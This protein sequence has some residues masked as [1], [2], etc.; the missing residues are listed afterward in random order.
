[1]VVTLRS[2][3]REARAA[4]ASAHAPLVD[5]S[6]S[7]EGDGDRG[8]PTWVPSGPEGFDVSS[9]SPPGSPM[10]ADETNAPGENVGFNLGAGSFTPKKSRRPRSNA[11]SGHTRGSRRAASP[12]PTTPPPTAGSESPELPSLSLFD[13][14]S[15]PVRPG[16]RT[17]DAAS[18]G[19]PRRSASTPTPVTHASASGTPESIPASTA[20]PFKK[21]PGVVGDASPFGPE[22][23]AAGS[24]DPRDRPFRPFE[25]FGV[26]RDSTQ[27]LDTSAPE[28]SFFAAA[29][30]QEATATP[31]VT[32]FS[33]LSFNLGSGGGRRASGAST[34]RRGSTRGASSGASPGLARER[35]EGNPAREAAPPP[36]GASAFASEAASF[37]PRARPETNAP[38]FRFT[39][40][41]PAASPPT[42][43]TFGDAGPRGGPFAATA[44][45][46]FAPGAFAPG[47][48]D[49]KP[50]TGRT[51]KTPKKKPSASA[52]AAPFAPTPPDRS[53]AEAA[54]DRV[55]PSI[56]AAASFSSPPASPA[57]ASR[58]SPLRRA[59]RP[60]KSASPTPSP[61]SSPMD[62]LRERVASVNLG[63][64][65]APDSAAAAHRAAAAGAA[66][67]SFTFSNASSDPR[68]SEA[69]RLKEAGNAAFKAG[70]YQVASAN[71][72]EA[73]ERMA[74]EFPTEP[75]PEALRDAWLADEVDA[76]LAG[77]AS[78]VAGGR[79]AAV[80]YANRAAARL[81]NVNDATRRGAPEGA[82]AGDARAPATRRALAA[83]SDVRAAIR[84]CRAALAADPSFR[85]ARLRAGT[86]LMRLG[87]FEDAHAEF[88]IAAEGDAGG[89]AAEA[90]RLA[91]DAARGG[92]LVDSLTRVDG[93]ALASLRR[94]CVEG[95]S[96][97]ARR[98]KTRVFRA[99]EGSGGLDGS[100]GDD[101]DALDQTNGSPSK[102]NGAATTARD[103]LRSVRD[104]SAVA[105]HC[106]AVAEARAR[107]LLWE[108]RFEDAAAAAD[109]EGLGGAAH[110]RGGCAPRDASLADASPRA[111]ALETGGERWRARVRA[112]ARFATGDL[113]GAAAAMEASGGDTRSSYQSREEPLAFGGDDDDAFRSVSKRSNASVMNDDASLVAARVA[114]TLEAA[115]KDAFADL[116]GAARAAHALRVQGNASFKAKAYTRASE[117]YSQAIDAVAD[118]PGGALGAAFAAVCLCNRAAAAHAE[119]R[120]A[121]ALADC[122]RALALNPARVKSL[123]RRAQLYT[124]S[125]M[126][127]AAADDLRRLL[128]TLAPA[129][130]VE[131]PGEEIERR[132]R[133]A[134]AD[135][136][137]GAETLDKTSLADLRDGV[138]A[139]L[140]EANAAA[141]G[142]PTPDHA[143]VLGL[144]AGASSASASGLG[145]V[146]DSDV[147]K[148]Y[149]RL[150]LKHHPDKS[151][152]GLPGWADA[153]ALRRDAGAV[154]KLVGEAH[155]ALASAEKR[156]AFDA[157]D[158][159]A[160]NA[161]DDFGFASAR[162]SA[163]DFGFSTFARDAARHAA[164]RRGGGGSPGG[165]SA[166]GGY[167]RAGGAHGDGGGGSFYG[168]W[169]GEDNRASGRGAYRPRKSGGG[170]G[171]KT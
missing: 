135:A 45:G 164:S 162:A 156:R 108:G 147:K 118:A 34:R 60:Q 25:G 12:M 68:A 15:W 149:R 140:R 157:A 145:P 18:E 103:V 130:R 73:L 54:K 78:F 104:V 69:T 56:F 137:A 33:N 61:P 46:A 167:R 5:Y 11:R 129:T 107:A 30:K 17:R 38:P 48:S 100:L 81:M 29:K 117:M 55:P 83:A 119:G 85:R 26:P 21:S 134:L 139:R 89:T 40:P 166:R 158:R 92:A 155:A 28:P 1:M 32:E 24:P 90:R 99:A 95:A 171:Y 98:V 58:R 120:V 65:D 160:R 8:D 132:A 37:F 131:Q 122:G 42:F 101:E 43:P 86:C 9:K 66:N 84:D 159:K 52:R 136:A 116:I 106:A 62:I 127:D 13:N 74:R 36:V 111:F 144:R 138:S 102:K 7:D 121:D 35:V 39:P 152:A 133:A 153:E 94:R 3:T 110:R 91:G 148:A 2:S 47:S 20:T 87:A 146:A 105:P 143:A 88:L 169:F 64:G 57:T 114:R 41:P 151:R 51:K 142:A 44:A 124:E 23:N 10:E 125:R 168:D 126:H 93:G 128:A 75:V 63:R 49:P 109:T 82:V 53:P 22:P 4:D 80:C 161:R 123:S 67:V 16:S 77:R 6:S 19:G 96:V 163:P 154:F 72:D 150:A 59:S 141:R 97:G 31:P 14:V 50:A 27:G 76:S 115:E 71:Y 112:A 165:G 70:R 79:D 170:G 113:A